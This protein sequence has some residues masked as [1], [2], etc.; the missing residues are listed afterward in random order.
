M[1][2]E[3]PSSNTTID[4]LSPAMQSTSLGFPAVLHFLQSEWRRFERERIEWEVERAEMQAKICVLEGGQRAMETL[5]SDLSRRIKML[6]YCLKEERAKRSPPPSSAVIEARVPG[7]DDAVTLHPQQDSNVQKQPGEQDQLQQK[8]QKQEESSVLLPFSQGG[9]FQRSRDILKSYLK[10]ADALLLTFETSRSTTSLSSIDAPC[11]NPLER[12]AT[13]V[14]SEGTGT[15]A[16][17]PTIL[18]K[19]A[20]TNNSLP[21]QASVKILVNP[22]SSGKTREKKRTILNIDRAG[23]SDDDLVLPDE[24]AADDAAILHFDQEAGL[25]SP[26][27]GEMPAIPDPGIA[28]D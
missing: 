18:Q 23:P 11:G 9:G 19:R 20:S 10:E 6:E 28:Q 4:A 17:Q 8:A 24:L 7:A 1:S 12:N 25:F 26:I 15:A 21:P 3:R 16:P 5:K 27:S 2:E 14:K 22:K 13:L